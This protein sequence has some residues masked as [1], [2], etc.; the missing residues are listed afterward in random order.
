MTDDSAPISMANTKKEML[1]AYDDLLKRLEAE[2]E[3]KMR[4]EDK[5][6]ERAKA[7]ATETADALSTDAVAKQ[8][9]GLKSEIGRMLNEISDKLESETTKY[10][11]VQEAVTAKEAELSEIYEIQK[12][13]LSLTALLEAQKQRREEFAAEMDVKKTNLDREISETKTRWKQEQAEREARVKERD[14]ADK[15][16]RDR[17]AEEYAYKTER[18]RELA[19]D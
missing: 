5:V 13:A 9:A 6:E 1:A 18:E 12:A 8:I 7:R 10:R 11:Q 4:P 15:Q 17:E 2:H 16:K 3:T 14:A 19:R